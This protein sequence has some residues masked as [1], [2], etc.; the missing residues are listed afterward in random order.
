[1]PE[2]QNI[3]WHSRAGKKSQIRP[4]CESQKKPDTMPLTDIIFNDEKTKSIAENTLVH[5]KNASYQQVLFFNEY[6]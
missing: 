2:Y 4:S 1:M 3:S 5:P 6:P